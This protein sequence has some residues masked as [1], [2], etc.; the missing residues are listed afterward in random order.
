MAIEPGKRKILVY[1]PAYLWF[2]TATV[3]VSLLGTGYFLFDR[4]RL[5]AGTELVQLRE[6]RREQERRIRDQQQE[7]LSMR[8]Q[9][10]VLQR[11]SEIDRLAS[12][13]VRNEFAGLQDELSRARK[14][15]Q[16][17]RGIVSPGDVKPGLRVQRINI[18]PAAEPDSYLYSL[19]LTQ[20]K[21]ND[22]YVSGVIDIDVEGM[23]DGTVKVLPFSALM[24]GDSK[25]L[26]YRFRY[27]QHFDG[28]IRVPGGFVPQRIMVRVVPQGKGQ[29]PAIEESMEWPV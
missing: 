12:L 2:A 14:E 13:N 28:V 24:T 4:G 18:E 10:A 11:S 3:A 8:E 9:I 26:K 17:Y 7:I 27:F 1:R 15:L 23:E 25:A 6:Q 29:P 22:R 20:V 16:F 19:T 21:R 5:S